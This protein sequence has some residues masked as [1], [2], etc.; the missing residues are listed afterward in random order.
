MPT[1]AERDAYV[2]YQ[3]ET[4]GNTKSTPRPKKKKSWWKKVLNTLTTSKTNEAAKK[5]GYG[6]Y[7]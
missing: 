6:K 2:K 7:K 3:Q 1:Q 4:Y 5:G